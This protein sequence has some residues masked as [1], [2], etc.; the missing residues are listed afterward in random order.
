MFSTY[1][2]ETREVGIGL[3]FITRKGKR[4]KSYL[5]YAKLVTISNAL[6]QLARDNYHIPTTLS[7]KQELVNFLNNEGTKE[8]LYL[9][10]QIGW[11]RNQYLLPRFKAGENIKSITLHPDSRAGTEKFSTKG[12]LEDWK[13]YVASPCVNNTR[14]VFALSAAFASPLIDILGVESIGMNV[15]GGSRIG[16]TVMLRVAGSVWGGNGK[17]DGYMESWDA[18]KVGLESLCLL[19]N[20]SFL[21]IDELSQ[22]DPKERERFTHKMADGKGKGR[23][24]TKGTLARKSYQWNLVFFSTANGSSEEYGLIT[25][26]STKLA[27]MARFCD[28]PAEA[29]NGIGIFDKVPDKVAGEIIQ[30]PAHFSKKLTTASRMYYG[31]PIRLFLA[32][33]VEARQS[34]EDNL[35]SD[36]E[37]LVQDF[38]AQMFAGEQSG[39]ASNLAERFGLLYA[40]GVLAVRYGVLPYTEKAIFNSVRRCHNDHWEWR[41][42]ND[43]KVEEKEGEEVSEEQILESVAG[44]INTQSHLILD[45]ANLPEDVAILNDAVGFRVAGG[46][47]KADEIWLK[48]TVLDEMVCKNITKDMLALVLKKSGFLN[49]GSRNR[50]RRQHTIKGLG[51]R[52]YYCLSGEITKQFSRVSLSRKYHHKGSRL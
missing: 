37:E 12:T 39:I 1:D 19:H 40:G 9:A 50:V 8:I 33:L 44:Y 45:R 51:R 13:K 11:Y 27:Q 52:P 32:Q 42:A 2:L 31:T 23:A 10:H 4:K 29:G 16:K 38:S 24:N 43:L 41:K 46:G 20:D 17:P 47:N 7:D 35:I 28:I 22:S 30:G 25:T 14:L 26:D 6:T 21:A 18:S 49:L 34:S 48:P 3:D 15:F 36:I 5:P